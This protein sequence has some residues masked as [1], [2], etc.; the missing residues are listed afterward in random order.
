MSFSV[1]GI[2]WNLLHPRATEEMVGYIPQFV[3][4]DD[5]RP[6]KEQLHTAYAHG[7][8]WSKFEGFLMADDGLQIV[9]PGDPPMRAIASAYLR[10]EK[11]VLYEG[12][13]LAI[14]QATGFEIAR[15]S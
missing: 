6:A 1:N 13:W 14:I 5:P 8:G 4:I 12:E 3:N 10:D 15:M 2:E 11:L 7:G 9:Y